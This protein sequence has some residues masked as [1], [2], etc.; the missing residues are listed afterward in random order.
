[1]KTSLLALGFVVATSTAA[2]A[3]TAEELQAKAMDLSTKVQTVIAA[4]PEKATEI[5]GKFTALQT[6]PPA[7]VESAC[8]VYDDLLAEIEAL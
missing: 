5:T 1:M 6:Q 7:D 3:C 8:K 4:H 2:F